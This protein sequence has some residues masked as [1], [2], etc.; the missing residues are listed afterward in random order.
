M[1]WRAVLERLRAAVFPDA[2][3]AAVL[4]VAERMNVDGMSRRSFL[5]AGLLAATVAATVDVEQLL[6]T[7]GEKTL[8][9]PTVDEVA[10]YDGLLTPD[11][12]TR[13]ALRILKNNLQVAGRTTREYA[14][15]YDRRGSRRG[16]TVP[17]RRRSGLKPVT[18]DQQYGYE[19]EVPTSADR[20]DPHRY[21]QRTVEPAMRHMA[22]KLDRA[23]VDVFSDLELPRGVE[24]ALVIRSEAVSVR[25]VSA[26]DITEQRMRMRLDVLGGS[27]TRRRR[28]A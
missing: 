9:L 16:D 19:F 5:R 23:R 13:E 17:I 10:I 3:A 27:S 28:R 2:E 22:G 6:W 26:Y 21:I 18:L 8:F 24:Q 14:E 4:D 20:K 12:I 11:W 1:N 25:S 15:S 7:P